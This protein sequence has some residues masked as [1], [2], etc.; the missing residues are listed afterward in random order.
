[1]CH[2]REILITDVTVSGEGIEQVE[3]SFY[4][5]IMYCQMQHIPL[6]RFSFVLKLT[7]VESKQAS[8]LS[9]SKQ[10]CTVKHWLVTD[11]ARTIMSRN[12][13]P[14]PTSLSEFHFSLFFNLTHFRTNKHTHSH[15]L[16]HNS[17]IFIQILTH[18]HTIHPYPHIH[19]HMHT[20][21][22]SQC[23]MWNTIRL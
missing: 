6:D 14:F 2:V 3:T 4:K 20:R 11:R 16:T 21:T 22:L 10:D 5:W 15:M 18:T 9:R 13:K 19:A 7:M 17:P 23:S 12:N 8:F 1:M